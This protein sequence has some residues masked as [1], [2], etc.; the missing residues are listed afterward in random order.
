MWD[1]SNLFRL[2][3]V[4]IVQFTRW[5]WPGLAV[6]GF[7]TLGGRSFRAT[8]PVIKNKHQAQP[9]RSS[10]IS[11][12]M[13]PGGNSICLCLTGVLLWSPKRPPWTAWIHFPDSYP[14]DILHLSF[15]F[16]CLL[17]TLGIY[18]GWFTLSG[19]VFGFCVRHRGLVY[20]N[21]AL[22]HLSRVFLSFFLMIIFFW[23][24]TSWI[25]DDV[26][27]IS[28]N[29]TQIIRLNGLGLTLP[30]PWLAQK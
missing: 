13:Q 16:L 30:W 11:G 15:N 17:V 19:S 1:F 10:V 28:N 9:G 18:L 21:M 22:Y 29:L 8:K 25:R 23:V 7:N 20:K 3:T 26:L 2:T 6:A 12:E 14:I 27:Y 5:F 4:H 24:L